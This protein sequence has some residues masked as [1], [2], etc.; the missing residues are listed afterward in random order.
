MKKLLV[1]ILVAC[2]TFLFLTEGVKRLGKHEPERVWRVGP[3]S[4]GTQLCVR[5]I[6]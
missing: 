4:D 1:P 5:R 3:C 6:K 2:A